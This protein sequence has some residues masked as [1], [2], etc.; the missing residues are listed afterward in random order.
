MSPWRTVSVALRAL[1][2]NKLRALLTTLGIIIGVA[3][4]VATMGIGEGATKQAEDQLRSLGTNFLMVFP[5]TTTSSGARA[6][7]GSSSKLSEGDVAAIRNEVHSVS[8]VSAANRS[9]AQ[10]VYGRLIDHLCDLAAA[11]RAGATA[12]PGLD[13]NLLPTP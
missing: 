12:A 10:V 9:V 3:C 2:R 11:P 6:G 4:V 8:Y 1:A 7:W 13:P 5:G